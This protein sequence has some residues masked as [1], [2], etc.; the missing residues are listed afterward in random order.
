MRVSSLVLSGAALL[1]PAAAQAHEGHAHDGLLA[2]LMH[3]VGGIDHLLV[4]L[5]LGL[6]AGLA[7]ARASA[8]AP[9]GGGPAARTALA[10]MLG[11]LAGAS[12]VLFG[13][14]GDA[15]S[16]SGWSVLL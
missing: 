7:A 16:L 8:G 15:S 9:G 13:G 14:P 6:V 4:T 10:V 11:L 1:L 2:G 5:G 12:W 3:P